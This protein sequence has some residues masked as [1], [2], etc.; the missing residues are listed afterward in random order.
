M[1]L[2]KSSMI[3]ERT[4]MQLM[5]V[6][7]FHNN[8]VLYSKKEVESSLIPSHFNVDRKEKGT[9]LE[10][11]RKYE[12]TDFARIEQLK[13]IMIALSYMDEF[14]VNEDLE[15]YKAIFNI[16]PKGIYIPRNKY[17]TA[18][19]HYPKHQD[20]ALA[21]INKMEINF[22]IPDYEMYQIIVNTFGVNSLVTKKIYCLLYWLP[23]FSQLNP[24][25]V[26]TPTPTDPKELAYLAMEKIS[27]IDC[28]SE[29]TIFRT[30]DVP[31]AIDDTWIVSAMSSSQQE[32]LAV[33]PI[34][35]SLYVE[36]PFPIWVNKYYL[37]YFVLKGDPITREVIYGEY[38][39]I[40]NLKIPFWE[41]HNFKIPV[42]IHEQEDG[43]FKRPIPF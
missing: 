33:Q 43:A 8:P 3:K 12:K 27:S 16:F 39:D 35:K 30:K 37:D 13:F 1:L 38:D 18:F 9:F 15:T 22:V 19:Y 21:I 41:K 4:R 10:I 36:G 26:P 14:D 40:S 7:C 24:W 23:K 5:I 20:T 34:D 2:N 32:L 29:L 28:Q 6:N 25:P 31:N 42:T 17:E 11:I